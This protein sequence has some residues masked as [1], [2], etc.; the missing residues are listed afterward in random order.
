MSK[1]IDEESWNRYPD[2][3]IRLREDGLKSILDGLGEDGF[4]AGTLPRIRYA[5]DGVYI[6]ILLNVG[7][8]GSII[9]EPLEIFIQAKLP[10][11]KPAKEKKVKKTYEVQ[12]NTDPGINPVDDVH[13]KPEAQT[14]PAPVL[15]G[16]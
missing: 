3:R 1:T 8:H 5:D 9:A 12:Q 2:S 6:D 10:V 15:D 11:P 13:D 14:G 7:K 4:C 16:V